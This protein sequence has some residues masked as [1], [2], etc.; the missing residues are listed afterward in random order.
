MTAPYDP[1]ADR[2][3]PLVRFLRAGGVACFVLAVASLAPGDLGRAA[4]GAVLALLIGL[5]VIRALWLAV[6][7]A[8][9]GD[10]RY[11]LVAVTAAA[12]VAIGAVV[13]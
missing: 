6:R 3:G 11:A 1:R 4:R 8:R 13:A 5:P 9:K 2:Q 7:W 10:A 12:I